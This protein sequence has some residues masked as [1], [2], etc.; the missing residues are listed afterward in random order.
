MLRIADGIPYATESGNKVVFVDDDVMVRVMELEVVRLLP[1][2][3]EG[4]L[5]VDLGAS[6]GVT[7]GDV[8][9]D[10]ASVVGAG[11]VGGGVIALPA[12]YFPF[13]F[14]D[15]VP[16]YG[17]EESIHKAERPAWEGDGVRLGD[18]NGRFLKDGVVVGVRCLVVVVEVSSQ[19]VVAVTG[20]VALARDSVVEDMA[21]AV[22]NVG[23]FGG[24][25]KWDGFEGAECGVDKGEVKEVAGVEVA[26][27][28]DESFNAEVT[29]EEELGH[30]VAATGTDVGARLVWVEGEED[31]FNVW[32]CEGAGFCSE[33]AVG[34]HDGCYVAE[35]DYV[36]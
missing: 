18:V 26:E 36:R 19:D 4:S 32:A 14:S 3:L 9:V 1:C 30:M 23:R 33:A 15:G 2:A 16:K 17:K 27:A 11:D 12:L 29:E 20:K 6:G 8:V 34:A 7:F 21:E 28:A 13:C 25:F 22:V 5:V 35:G 10:G 31:P 24:V